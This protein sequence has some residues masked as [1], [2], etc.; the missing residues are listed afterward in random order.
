MDKD[1]KKYWIVVASKDHVKIAEAGGF[2][3]ANH[4]KRAP[5]KKLNKGD[6]VICYSSKKTLG[7]STPYQKFTAIGVI[8]DDE[9]YIGIMQGGNFKPYR[10]NVAFHECK[11]ADIK[12]LISSLSFI[13]NKA[14][15]G[16]PF[17]RGFFEIPAS[18]FQCIANN[19][20]NEKRQ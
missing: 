6:Q 13:K 9:P 8:T 12:P 3:Q 1:D 10:R 7:E 11:E 5:M 20:L 4:G 18:D 14:K 16:F 17:M 19:M 2:I 15:W